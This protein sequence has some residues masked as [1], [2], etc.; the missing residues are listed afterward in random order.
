MLKEKLAAQSQALQI[1]ADNKELGTKI[2]E[3]LKKDISGLA[4]IINNI[5]KGTE[6]EIITNHVYSDCRTTDGMLDLYNKK[7][8]LQ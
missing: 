4:P 1:V 3:Q 2:S 8:E 5:N 7:L 6:R